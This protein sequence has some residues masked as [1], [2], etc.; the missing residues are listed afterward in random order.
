[1]IPPIDLT[2]HRYG[3]LVVSGFAGKRGKNRVWHCKCDCGSDYVGVGHH[4][5]SGAVV[6]CGCYRDAEIAARSTT[7]GHRRNRQ[8]TRAHAVWANMLERCRNDKVPNW[9]RYGGRGITVDPR[10]DDFAAFLEDMGE[11]PP[12]MTLDRRDNDGPY[13]KSNCRW[14]TRKQQANNRGG[15]R[16]PKERIHA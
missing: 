8:R 16:K 3:R 7:H 15:Q 6:S 11:P 10:W 5:R 1:M 2:G 9:Y 13:T 12:G 4:M 14:A